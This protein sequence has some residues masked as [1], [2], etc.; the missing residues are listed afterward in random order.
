MDAAELQPL[1]DAYIDGEL[2][3]EQFARLDV[4]LREDTVQVLRFVEETHLHRQ[5]HDL[6]VADPRLLPLGV[7]YDEDE[8]ADDDE[9]APAARSRSPLRASA[10]RVAWRVGAFLVRPMPLALTVAA[11]VIVSLVIALD[12]M[13]MPRFFG[14]PGAS[15]AVSVVAQLTGLYEARWAQGQKP[16]VVDGPLQV[17]DQLLIDAGL[18]EITFDSHARMVVEGPAAVTIVGANDARLDRGRLSARVPSE[19]LGFTVLTPVARFIDLGTE[20]GTCVTEQTAEAVVFEGKIAVEML[21]DDGQPGRRQEMAAGEAFRV[22]GQTASQI[23]PAQV[24]GIGGRFVRELP[25][26]NVRAIAKAYT[27]FGT[28]FPVVRRGLEEG[29]LAY[30]DRFYRWQEIEGVC[31]PEFLRGAEYVAPANER[32]HD[33]DLSVRVVLAKPATLYLL[34]DDRAEVPDWLKSTFVDTQVDIGMVEHRE[35]AGEEARESGT[36]RSFSIWKRTVEEP[37]TVVLYESNAA[38]CS[39][40]GIAAVPLDQPLPETR[41][42][43]P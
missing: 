36:E 13:S 37:G 38:G 5:V 11:V 25:E 24:V 19:A 12:L 26:A 9:L 31:F 3:D 23:E 40:Y 6:L 2:T 8:W 21:A 7:G 42:D 30:C 20:F 27:N 32:K 16:L 1:I 15:Q 41:K 39:M 34:F 29:S 14:Q 10:E 35:A 22:D 18:A 28:R 4:L 43:K 33:W 17:G